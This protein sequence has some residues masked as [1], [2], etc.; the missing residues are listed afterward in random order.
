MSLS[1]R[2]FLTTGAASAAVISGATQVPGLLLQAAAA[3]PSRSDRSEN[4]LIVLQL[5]G[6][7]DGLN[8]VVPFAD[9]VYARNRFQT[10]ISPAAVHKLD[11]YLGLHPSMTG[12]HRLYEEDRLTIIQGVGYAHPNRSHF[13][14]MDI[15]HTGLTDA[16]RGARNIGW[17]GRTLDAERSAA[18]GRAEDDVPAVHLGNQVQPLALA[19]L[20]VQVPSIGSFD[21][22]QFDD[23]GDRKLAAVRA[24]LIAAPADPAPAD[25]GNELLAHVR[26]A[27]QTALSSSRRVGKA[28]NRHTLA[29]DYPKT[30]LGNKLRGIARLIQAGLSTRIYYVTLDGFDTHSLQAES[31]AGLLRE[32]SGGVTAL[33]DDLAEAGQLERVMLAC[34]SEF[35]RRV[36]ENASRG[37]DHGA[38]APMFLAGGRLRGGLVGEHP[39]LTDLEDGDLKFHTDFR[40]VYASLLEQ[41]L[42]VAGQPILG[43]VFQPLKIFAG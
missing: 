6:G 40:R 30:K 26:A 4:V 37:T 7:N 39:S 38:A 3:T 42:G 10:K 25:H 43:E 23:L 19:G 11:D 13:D 34:F 9:D 36:K 41:W 14:S 15:W 21:D 16:A 35:G 20:H 27:A 2:K 17:L 1:R 32:L 33:F 22:F 12:M 31:H 24:R 18:A 29:A 8:T 28:L 5:S